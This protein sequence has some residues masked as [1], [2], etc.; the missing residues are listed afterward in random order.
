MIQ[1]KG[2]LVLAI[3]VGL[4][5]VGSLKYFHLILFTNP[6]HKPMVVAQLRHCHFYVIIF[7]Q[8]HIIKLT[9]EYSL[10]ENAP[11]SSKE[12]NLIIR[13]L[14]NLLK[15]KCSENDESLSINHM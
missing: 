14:S 3:V 12:M 6:A 2:R 15:V 9:D 5:Y 7:E 10:L 11:S 8:S 4:N 13:N 1:N